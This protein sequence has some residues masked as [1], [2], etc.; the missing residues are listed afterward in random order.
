MR[1]LILQ[2]FVSADG[3]AA[4]PD[5][6]LDFTSAT[7][8]DQSF[9]DHQMAFIDS[10][11]TMVLGR[12]TYEMFVDYWPDLTEGDDKRFAEK[13]NNLQKVIVS[14]TLTSAPWG[15]FS[16]GRVAGF[17]DVAA[18]KDGDGKD[19]VVWGS[20]SLAQSLMERGLFD[21]YQL[22]VCP[23]VLGNGL[24]LFR[25]QDHRRFTLAGTRA[26]DGGT[27]LLSYRV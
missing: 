10:L 27:V 17:E 20:I 21:E 18:L 8:G 13:L 11:D 16:P 3:M 7:E 26:F 15:S 25:E 6:N 14:R 4:G 19:V 22:V 12:R 5:G 2:E 9:G 1:K 23:V 24:R